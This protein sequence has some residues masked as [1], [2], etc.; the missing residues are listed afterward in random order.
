MT[1][2]RL[3]EMDSFLVLKVRSW[4]IIY[5]VRVILMKIGVFKVPR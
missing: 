3:D 5:E 2:V 1:D 4:A